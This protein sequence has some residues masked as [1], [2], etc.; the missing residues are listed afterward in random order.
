MKKVLKIAYW[1]F[2]EKVKRKSFLIYI[3]LFPLL[4]MALGLI[5][6]MFGDMGEESTVVIG[7]LDET[8]ELYP[9]L[10]RELKNYT[11]PNGN[12]KFLVM[13][14]N[15]RVAK[16]DSKNVIADSLVLD[17][18]LRGYLNIVKDA[19]SDFEFRFKTRGINYKSFAK[20]KNAV[21]NAIAKHNLLKAG[22]N[23][24]NLERS[25]QNI[26]IEQEILQQDGSASKDI[27][28]IFFS[29]YLFIMLLLMM[30]IFSGGLLVRSIVEEKS[31][32]IIEILI[33]SCS[34]KQLLAGKIIGLSFLGLFQFAVWFTMGFLVI[35][36]SVI[37]FNVF[38]NLGLQIAYFILGYILFTALFVGIGSI[39]TNEQEAQQFTGYISVILVIPIIISVQIIQNPHSLLSDILSYFPLTSPPI[40]ILKL[41]FSEPSFTEI[42]ST[43]L[44]IL[45]SIYL[46]I[47]L[48][49]KIFKIG[50]LSYGKTPSIREL[51]NWLRS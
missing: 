5:P 45:L 2:I 43:I 36:S 1:E 38:H 12:P 37:S 47:F 26:E 39:V 44:I 27:L 8:D 13:N 33:S 14:L 32:R 6:S 11:L 42:I 50:I 15:E 34:P 10:N 25:F 7:V 29:A 28:T 20:L 40:M 49:S 51:R 18:L 16:S 4:L 23:R 35:S 31:N 17:G 30:I 46:I 24:T 48:T 19:N 21:N 22:I 9:E 41:N 3:I